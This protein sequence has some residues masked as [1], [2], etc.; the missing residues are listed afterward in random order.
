MPMTFSVQWGNPYTDPPEG[1]P[2]ILITRKQEGPIRS[3]VPAEVEEVLRQVGVGKGWNLFVGVAYDDISRRRLSPEAKG[4]IRRRALAKRVQAKAP[5]FADQ[6]I[7]DKLAAQ[8]DYYSG[9][10]VSA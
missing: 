7:A 4:K 5:L 6:I 9:I 8:P 2:R 1:Q 10:E 3:Q